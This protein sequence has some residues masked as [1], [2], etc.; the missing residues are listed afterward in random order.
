MPY[1]T[2]KNTLVGMLGAPGISRIVASSA[3]TS[4]V[5]IMMHRFA[6]AAVGHAGHSPSALKRS[7]SE[8]RRAGIEMVDVEDAL[9]AFVGGNGRERSR[10]PRRPR[11]AFTIDDGYADALEL[12]GPVFAEFDCPVTCFVAPDVV[13][14]KEW[15]W[16][17]KVETL[18]QSSSRHELVFDSDGEPVT[19]SLR[20]PEERTAAFAAI[21]ALI[22]RL[23]SDVVPVFLAKVA[24]ATDTELPS[25][26]P[27][28]YRVLDWDTMRSAEQRGWRFGAHSMT[29][30]LMG[31]CTD[32]RAE[33]E[34]GESIAAVR[35]RLTNPSGVFCYPVGLEGDFGPREFEI[36]RREGVRWALSAIPGRL[37]AGQVAQGDPS[38]QWRI[39]RFAHD[40]R[41]GGILRMFLG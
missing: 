10:T 22:K 28:T 16:W 1:S 26:P 27:S 12:A 33:W 3:G 37:R 29:H 24:E 30:P 5:I 9:E 25:T 2:L 18:L 36:L 7:L 41:P 31:R 15:Y 8:L 34:I 35:A 13:D 21:C 19:L 40:E 38:W 39:P 4:V 6:G 11:V 17:D 20:T 23:P 32:A 14:A